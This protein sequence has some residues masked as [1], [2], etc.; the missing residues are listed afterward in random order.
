M[1]EGDCGPGYLCACESEVKVW[2]IT[3]PARDH[4]AAGIESAVRR[5]TRMMY[6]LV[7]KVGRLVVLQHKTATYHVLLHKMTGF[8]LFKS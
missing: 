4:S 7:Q 3:A 5:S 6:P 1:A 2:D 8:L